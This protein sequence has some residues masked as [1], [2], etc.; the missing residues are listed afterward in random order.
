MNKEQHHK[1]DQDIAKKLLEFGESLEDEESGYEDSDPTK[2]PLKFLFGVIF[3]QSWKYENAWAAPTKLEKRLGHLD[4]PK[5]SKMKQHDL[6]AKLSATP[7]LHRFNNKM[8]GWIIS[9]SKLLL[10]KY[11]GDAGKIWRTERKGGVVIQRLQEFDGIVQKKGSMAVNILVRDYMFPLSRDDIDISYDV[12]VGRVFVRTGLATQN[13][14][15]DVVEAARRLNPSYPGALDYP[16][17]VVGRDW[18]HKSSPEC[19]KC[20]LREVC[21][22]LI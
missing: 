16:T 11:D 21:P 5:I 10:S 13:T 8:A 6:E 7:A 14:Q 12:H 3:D 17:W 20:V 22:K 4:V 18:C 19:P 15:D 9:A 1:R 2:N